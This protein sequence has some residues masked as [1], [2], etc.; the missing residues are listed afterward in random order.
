MTSTPSSDITRLLKK[1]RDQAKEI[2][3][4]NKRLSEANRKLYI[5]DRADHI[6]YKLAPYV[7]DKSFRQAITDPKLKPV[8]EELFAA[9]QNQCLA[10]YDSLLHKRNMLTHR[11]TARQW[12]DKHKKTKHGRSIRQLCDSVKTLSILKK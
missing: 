2:T 9:P 7:P 1:N 12:V 8:I 11:Y 10:I 6:K 5:I 3:V 4:L